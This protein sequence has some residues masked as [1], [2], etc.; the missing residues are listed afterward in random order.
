MNSSCPSLLTA[1]ACRVRECASGDACTRCEPV[2]SQTASARVK[3]TETRYRFASGQ[4]ASRALNIPGPSIS[5]VCNG[6]QQAANGKRF[7]FGG[8]PGDPPPGAP[9]GPSPPPVAGA[10]D[11]A[12]A[13]AQVRYHN[14]HS[15]VDRRIAHRDC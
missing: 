12:L 8:R 2:R 5:V 7:R 3:T 4:A 13:R 9:P 14:P 11:A 1:G 6:K 10:G 15:S